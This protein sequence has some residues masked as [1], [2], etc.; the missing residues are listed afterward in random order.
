[1]SISPHSGAR[2]IQR[3]PCLKYFNVLKRKNRLTLG[4]NA[5]KNNDYMKKSL[6]WKFLRIQFPTKNSV[7]AYIYLPLLWS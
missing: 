1:M 5:A 3:L 4:L 7:D 6:K 2:W